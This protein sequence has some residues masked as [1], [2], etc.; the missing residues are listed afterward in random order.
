MINHFSFFISY[1]EIIKELSVEDSGAFIKAISNY[2][3]EGIQPEFDNTT[4]K[5]AWK[6]IKPNLDK[7]LTLSNNSKRA[8][9]S[10]K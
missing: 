1:H 5:I 7:S 8:N 6:A 4:L 2:M 9:K 3:F 10:R